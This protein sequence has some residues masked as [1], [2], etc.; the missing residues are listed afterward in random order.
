MYVAASYRYVHTLVAIY[1]VGAEIR[2]CFNLGAEDA[3]IYSNS[4]E[5]RMIF[6]L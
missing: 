1:I 5:I 4:E 3:L 2:R 6:S